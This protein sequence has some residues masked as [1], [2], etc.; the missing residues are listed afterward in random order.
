MGLEETCDRDATVIREFV[1][2]H[3][4]VGKI[5]GGKATAGEPELKEGLIPGV[6]EQWMYDLEA[7]VKNCRKLV[8]L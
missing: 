2:G 1:K 7:T 5:S 4:E 3:L 8:L 6:S